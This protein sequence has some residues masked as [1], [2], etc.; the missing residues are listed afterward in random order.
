MTSSKY[1]I[2][3]PVIVTGAT[4]FLGKYITRELVKRGYEVFVITRD[5]N[6]AAAIFKQDQVNIITASLA[7]APSLL[8]I[9]EKAGIFHCAGITG[10]I[11]ASQYEYNQINIQ[12][13]HNLLKT[14]IKK[15]SSYFTFVSSI[16][17]VGAV[18]SL[19]NPILETTKPQ[20]KTYY[21]I[22]KLAAE[23]ILLTEAPAT[24]PITIV[25]PTLIYGPG[26]SALSGAELLFKLCEKTTIPL[27]GGNETFIPLIYVDNA[28]TGI[29]DLSL[30]NQGKEIFNLADPDD[31]T[32]KT[33][34]ILINNHSNQKKRFI[35]IPYSLINL[36]SLA[37]NGASWLFKKD[38]GLSLENIKILANN[39]FVM[40]IDKSFQFGYQ[41][42]F[43]LKEGIL[44]TYKNLK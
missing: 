29:I 22:S 13:T 43:T 24:L 28:A 8:K 38:F 12:G 26:Q 15:Q 39:G 36:I 2:K 34:A 23:N 5:Y 11:H 19:A 32:I 42:K 20:P 4:G 44:L 18:G 30:H 37:M 40:K 3:K 6:K 17:A 10:S 25:R 27:I 14:A 16:S 35:T 41:P 21:G 31:V 1:K 7:D 9:P 33:L